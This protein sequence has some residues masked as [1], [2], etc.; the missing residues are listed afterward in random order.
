M[1]DGPIVSLHNLVQKVYYPLIEMEVPEKHA[2]RD[3]L[4]QMRTALVFLARQRGSNQ[5]NLDKFDYDINK[6][7]GILEPVDELEIWKSLLD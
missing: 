5:W 3:L 4:Y 2:F 7:K 1:I 6:F